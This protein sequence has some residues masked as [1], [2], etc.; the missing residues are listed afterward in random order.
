M[1]GGSRETRRMGRI[2]DEE[3]QLSYGSYLRIPQLLELQ[4]PVAEPPAHDEHLFIVVHQAFELWFKEI[5]FELAS[6]R[7]EMFAGETYRPRH[8]IE[9]VHA[10]LRILIEQI[11]VLETMSPQDFLEFRSNLSP[12]SGFQSVQF[13]EIEFVSGL[14]RKGHRRLAETDEER[15][16]LDRRLAEPTVWDGFRALMERNSLPM[17]E[18]DEDA[19]RAS[20]LKMVRD[21]EA[22]AEIFALS[23]ALLTYDEL[24][25]Q[26]RVHHILMVER[27]IGS[28]TGTG[29]SSGAE[30]L[31]GTLDS[32]FFPELWAL[33]S[34]L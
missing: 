1:A 12:A 18:D 2:S 26:W 34:H 32:R 13:R 25:A 31:R 16:R 33:R 7:D 19:R 3:G 30:Y 21:R 11:A 14:K 22:F 10:I 4:T 8:Y 9:R 27:E 20:L 23:E 29:G 24:F 17:P 5:V 6:A 28:K 15:Q